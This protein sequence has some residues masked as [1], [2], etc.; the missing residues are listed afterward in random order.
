MRW[1]AA[2]GRYLERNGYQFDRSVNTMAGG[3]PTQT[4]SERSAY[5]AGWRPGPD[6]EHSVRTGERILGWC[7]FCKFLSYAVQ[8]RHCALQFTNKK[9]PALTYLR[10][11]IA[12]G[13]GFYLLGAGI[14]ELIILL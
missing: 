6:P 12:F 10:A 8:H 11:G 3:D 2:V 9:S 14:H 4:V 1:I 5:G 7:I 13:V